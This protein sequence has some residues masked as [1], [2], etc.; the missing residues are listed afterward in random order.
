MIGPSTFADYRFVVF[1]TPCF[2]EMESPG[3]PGRFTF[4][5]DRQLE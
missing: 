1:M 4:C 5:I 2:K 3:M